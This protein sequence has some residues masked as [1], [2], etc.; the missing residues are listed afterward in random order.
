MQ[1]LDVGSGAPL[2]FGRGRWL[3]LDR[4]IV[5]APPALHAAILGAIRDMGAS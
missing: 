2:D 1:T 5:T 4:G 3:D